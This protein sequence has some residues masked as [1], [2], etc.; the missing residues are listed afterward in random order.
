[1][2]FSLGYFLVGS[3]AYRDATFQ[4]KFVLQ[5]KAQLERPNTNTTVPLKGRH[6]TLCCGQTYQ[7]WFDTLSKVCVPLHGIVDLFCIFRPQFVTFPPLQCFISTSITKKMK[8]MA[9]AAYFPQECYPSPWFSSLKL[10]SHFVFLLSQ[11]NCLCL[12]FFK[13]L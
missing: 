5:K 2:E 12:L 4:V 8:E 11:A 13:V 9:T 7:R 10:L 1:M 3:L 6:M